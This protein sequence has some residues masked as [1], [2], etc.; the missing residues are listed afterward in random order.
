MKKNK[1]KLKSYLNLF[2]S[3]ILIFFI[4]GYRKFISPFTLPSCRYLP[5]CSD[6]AIQAIQKKGVIKG[7]FLTFKRL[8]RCH[9]LAKSRVDEV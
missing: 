4:K 5:T 2:L 6:Y 3:K 8:L 9:P 7:S 1:K